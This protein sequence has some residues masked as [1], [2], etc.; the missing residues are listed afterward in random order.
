MVAAAALRT[1]GV[2][3]PDEVDVLLAPPVLGG[4]RTV[5]RV[6]ALL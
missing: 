2:D 4:G 5:G 6:R 3:V 1:L